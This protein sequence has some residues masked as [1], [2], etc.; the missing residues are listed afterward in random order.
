[1]IFGNPGVYLADGSYDNFSIVIE[2]F[3]PEFYSVNFC[4]DLELFPTHLAYNSK[5]IIFNA[6]R[7]KKI[8]EIQS[9]GLFGFDNRELM[10]ALIK[11][12]FTT[13]YR[14]EEIINLNLQPKVYTDLEI[15]AYEAL[16]ESVAYL[17]E[18]QDRLWNI[19]WM[20]Y[21]NRGCHVFIVNYQHETKVVLVQMKYD[22]AQDFKYER[23][24]YKDKTPKKASFFDENYWSVK[25]ATLPTKN[26]LSINSQILNE[27]LTTD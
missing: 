14:I 24:F 20:E 23:Y 13:L 19:D 5:P 8:F 6:F 22:Y 9:K 16:F 26:L 18:N 2:N 3:T 27:F 1:M 11:E 10:I 4:I 17:D 25:V 15:N 7:A 12:S 21:S